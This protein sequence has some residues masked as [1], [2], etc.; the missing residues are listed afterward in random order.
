MYSQFLS[1]IYNIL[2]KYFLLS[3][4]FSYKI[5]LSKNYCDYLL[6]SDFILSFTQNVLL[7]VFSFC[8]INWIYIVFSYHLRWY[9]A[10][11]HTVMV[12]TIMGLSEFM[13]SNAFHQLALHLYTSNDSLQNVIL[14]GVVSK[15]LYFFILYGLS[16]I[17][18]SKFSNNP[19]NISIVF[20]L[21][22]FLCFGITST[23]L[24]IG[25][26]VELPSHFGYLMA[27]S[28]FAFNRQYIRLLPLLLHPTE[29]RGVYTNASTNAK[30]IRSGPFLSDDSR[31]NRCPK[32][33]DSR[34]QETPLCN[35]FIE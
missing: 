7:N 3:S 20:I 27:F 10:L 25:Y 15:Q 28:S 18:K 29:K 6:N 30:G 5:I 16:H 31:T 35:F 4:M 2:L 32:I 12:T 13:V 9:Y 1:T 8:L 34:Y 22:S 24:V 19:P 21:I 17:Y 33:C 11:F 23:L 14:L 26:Y